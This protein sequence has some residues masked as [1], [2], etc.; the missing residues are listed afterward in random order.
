V[1]T[2]GWV[3]LA[4]LAAATLGLL[5]VWARTS[6]RLRG[7]TARVGALEDRLAGL[8]V[9]TDHAIQTA[10]AAAALARR[11]GPDDETFGAPRVVLEPV[12]GPIVK[13]LAWSAGARRVVTRL[14]HP[15]RSGPR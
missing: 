9:T 12:T 6:A 14:T 5:V 13:A 7:V 8:D 1:S 2:L 10:R 15:V 4:V 11:A 3:A